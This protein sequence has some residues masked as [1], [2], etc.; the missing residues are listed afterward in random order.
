MNKTTNTNKTLITNY[1]ALDFTDPDNPWGWANEEDFLNQ[2]GNRLVLRREQDPAEI[3]GLLLEML[4][5]WV[6]GFWHFRHVVDG[7]FW[8][9]TY[10][11]E[12]SQYDVEETYTLYECLA[13][14]VRQLEMLRDANTV[15][16]PEEM[17][18][19]LGEPFD[20]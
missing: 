1:N 4:D 20:D 13:K 8:C 7:L 3:T 11:W 16:T 12:G 9:A 10:T 14:M 17:R 5:P 6:N 15:L 19:Q 18:E 2:K